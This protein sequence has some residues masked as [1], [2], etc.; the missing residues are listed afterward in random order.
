V[1]TELDGFTAAMWMLHG[2]VRAVFA[3]TVEDGL[4]REIE[5]IMDD[6]SRLDLGPGRPV[7]P[8]DRPTG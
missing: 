5:L 6:V 2:E 4:V 8:G 3:F 1:L 7:P